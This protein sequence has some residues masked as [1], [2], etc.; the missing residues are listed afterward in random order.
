MKRVTKS[1]IGNLIPDGFRLTIRGAC[2][3]LLLNGIHCIP[4]P[5]VHSDEKS[6]SDDG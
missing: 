4:L 1:G 2:A 6:I 3:R 5:G